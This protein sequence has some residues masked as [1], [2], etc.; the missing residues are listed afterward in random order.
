MGRGVA[1]YACVAA[2]I[3]VLVLS[4]NTSFADFPRVC[5]ML[6]ADG[7]LPEP[8]VYR[9]RR[10]TFSYGI[11]VLALLVGALLIAFSGVTDALIPLFAI[12][13]LSAFTSSQLGMVAHW[14]KSTEPG[15]LRR[16]V[17]NALGLVATAGTL[18]IV[19]ASKFLEG[20]W[21][22]V[23][24]VVGLDVGFRRFRARRDALREATKTAGSLW[25]G[26]LQPPI[27]I[28]PLRRWD[29]PSLR[30]MRFALGISAEVIAVQV[31]T[32]D[33]EVDELTARWDELA[34]RPLRGERAAPRLVVLRSAYREL[35]APLLALVQETE[36]AHPGRP[37]AVVVPELIEAGWYHRLAYH[38][39]ARLLKGLLLFRGSSQTV[40]V[41][42]PL[43][44]RVTTRP[45]DQQE[46]S[47]LR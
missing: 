20:A 5:R 6:A 31:L 14:H 35:Y 37:I 38:H 39:T 25:L 2:V 26:P 28:V 47:S 34:I 3:S 21:I 29:A 19:L 17:L 15:A 45:H 18:I 32:Q 41:S 43:H 22:S 23:L 11:V 36:A 44:L 4:A 12:G 27:A 1:Y 13:A 24:L 8:F 33:R 7:F 42:V 40:I 16:L 30:A 10:L 9:G 46:E